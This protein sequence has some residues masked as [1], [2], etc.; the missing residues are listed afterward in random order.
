MRSN[1]I[2]VINLRENR[3]D[4]QQATLHYRNRGQ[5]IKID[6][7][8]SKTGSTQNGNVTKS[9]FWALPLQIMKTKEI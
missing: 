8:L 1:K 9:L 2:R 6:V 5:M 4:G 3:R 7:N